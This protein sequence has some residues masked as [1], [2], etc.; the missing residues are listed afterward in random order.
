M[1]T[2]TI[3]HD[4]VSEG[5]SIITDEKGPII[6]LG[7]KGNGRMSLVKLFKFNPAVIKDNMISEAYLHKVE[8]K[9]KET[10]KVKYSYF[11]IAKPDKYAC[12][13]IARINTSSPQPMPGFWKTLHG[14]VAKKVS[15]YGFDIIGER[16][17]YWQDDLV[18]FEPGSIALIG[19]GKSRLYVRNYSGCLKQ[20]RKEEVQGFI[21]DFN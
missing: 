7:Q 6:F 17:V 4:K 11:T 14:E 21:P 1:K 5:L 16:K 9:D 15:G 8:V 2:F 12:K 19:R 13:A 10:R 18:V 20:I 3:A